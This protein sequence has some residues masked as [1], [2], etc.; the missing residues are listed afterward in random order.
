MRYIKKINY[1][2]FNNIIKF[3][4]ILQIIP[5]KDLSWNINIQDYIDNLDIEI[6]ERNNAVF[7]LIAINE[8]LSKYK[9]YFFAYIDEKNRLRAYIPKHGNLYNPWTLSHFG[10]ES[11]FDGFHS[12]KSITRMPKQYYEFVPELGNF[13]ETEQYINDFEKT[14]LEENKEKMISEF[15]YF[16]EVLIK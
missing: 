14:N 13:Q 15:L 3:P 5:F 4:K 9:V 7:A 11:P 1:E 2:E 16:H 10:N 8:N 6:I 12:L